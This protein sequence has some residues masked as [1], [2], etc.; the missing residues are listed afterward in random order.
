MS[1][2]ERSQVVTSSGTSR[3]GEATNSR[4]S[5]EEPEKIWPC[6]NLRARVRT[7]V[8]KASGDTW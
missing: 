7:T 4:S 6:G 5:S 8:R 3:F 1:A 2:N